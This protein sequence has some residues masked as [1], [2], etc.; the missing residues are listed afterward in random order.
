MERQ[1][2]A[3]MAASTLITDEWPCAREDLTTKYTK[4]TKVKQQ[5]TECLTAETA[6]GFSVFRVF[7]G[8]KTQLIGF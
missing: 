7:R 4:H 3:Q 6:S 1:G 8:S 5:K 2:T